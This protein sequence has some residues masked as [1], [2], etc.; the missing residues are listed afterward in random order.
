[1]SCDVYNELHTRCERG[2]AQMSHFMRYKPP[3]WQ[4]IPDIRKFAKDTQA[5][6]LKTTAEIAKHQQVCGICKRN[7]SN[8]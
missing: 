7:F 6:I 1:M 3:N 2:R 4:A 5:E 8:S